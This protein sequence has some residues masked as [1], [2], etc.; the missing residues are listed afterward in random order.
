MDDILDRCKGCFYGLAVGDAFG[1]PVEFQRRDTFPPVTEMQRCDTWGLPAGSY[2][3]DTSMMLCLAAAIVH[4]GGVQDPHTVL[5]HYAEW[6]TGGY[7]SVNGECFDIGYA[8]K[9]ALMD[10]LTDGRLT[11]DADEDMSGNGS[12]MRL[13]PVPILW[14]MAS[15]VRIWEE[16]AKSSLTTHGSPQCLWACGF[17]AVLLGKILAGERDKEALLAGIEGPWIGQHAALERIVRRDFL[18][19]SRDAISSSGY[20]VDTLEAALWAF[21]QTTSFEEGLRLIV[22]LGRDA[23]TTG[24]VFGMLGGAYYGFNAIPARWIAALQKPAMLAGVFADLWALAEPRWVTSEG[25]CATSEDHRGTD[26]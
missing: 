9:V 8:T 10:F 12:L 25:T 16:A 11:A 15:E 20:V 5:S 7:M 21:F 4:A 22:N 2:T 26:P 14:G 3:D 23:D 17:Y 13:A 24:A 6:F 19:K 18:T 1:A